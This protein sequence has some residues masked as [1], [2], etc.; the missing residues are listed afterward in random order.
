MT[1]LERLKIETKPAHDRIEKALD[2]ERRMVSRDAYKELLIR[3]HGFHSAWE[4]AAVAVV[5]DP[6]FFRQRC[7]TALLAKDLKALGMKDEEV[8]ALPRC[9]PLMPLQAPAAALGS[10]YVVEGSTLGGAII[11]RNVERALGLTMDTGCAYFRS[12]GREVAFM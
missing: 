6:E 10:M 1:L 3:F 8:A 5:P 11:A 4:E 7:K 12:Y 9:H 2:V